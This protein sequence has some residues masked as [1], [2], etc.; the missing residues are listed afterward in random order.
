MLHLHQLWIELPLLQECHSL[1]R[2]RCQILI[3]EELLC[4]P[5]PCQMLEVNFF[6]STSH[7]TRGSYV[8][9][10]HNISQ[11]PPPTIRPSGDASYGPIGPDP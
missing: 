8:P 2:I 1:F 5:Y 9:I 11:P 4:L 10:L 6:L 7:T 3:W